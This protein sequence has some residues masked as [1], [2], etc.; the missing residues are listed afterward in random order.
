MAD[1]LPDGTRPG[2]VALRVND[3]ARLTEFY[4]TVVGLE[5]GREDGDR[6]VLGA[7]GTPLLELCE[8]PAAPE[9]SPEE[10]GLFHTA[11]RV[12]SRAALGAALERVEREWRLDGASDHLV[13]EALYLSDPEDNGVEIYRDRPREDW[14]AAADG[15]VEME[16]LGLDL[17][18]LR[19]LGE[20]AATAPPATTVGHVHLEVADLPAARDFYRTLGLRVRQQYGTSAAFLAAGDY[21]HHV[22]VNVWNGR[23]A[24]LAGRGLAWFELV[25]PDEGDLAAVRE[26][27]DRRDVTRTASDALEVTDPDGISLRLRSRR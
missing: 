2:R 25:V 19:D 8:D 11:F 17:D 1:T 20:A 18:P 14:P 13:S 24:S 7:G 21:H 9:R 6:T 27:V 16:T 12:P 3:R 15:R 5:V 23:S 22:G 4:A 26:R 10:T